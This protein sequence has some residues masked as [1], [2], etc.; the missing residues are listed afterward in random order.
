MTLDERNENPLRVLAISGS[1]RKAS[2]NTGLL[3]A[4]REIAPDG[5]EI[6]IFDIKDLPFYDGD[7]ESQGDPAPVTAL[8]SAVRDA[9]AVLFA[10]PEYNWGTSGA[11]K[12]A[13]DWAS[14]D[15]E[16]GSLMGK[17]GT[18]IGA[19][20][21]AGTARAQMQLLETLGETGTIVMVKP[22]VMVMA[23]AP[24]K[25]DSEGNLIDEETKELLRRHLDEFTKWIT[26]LIQPREFVPHACEMDLA[27]AQA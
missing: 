27:P 12:N 6:T 14:R 17:P 3:R 25:F 13:I 10:T 7:V 11:L 9:D 19:G 24:M 8:K 4:A 16:E 20:G 26:Q 22:G 15:R 23:F 2:F 18:I 5:M 21:R 1:L